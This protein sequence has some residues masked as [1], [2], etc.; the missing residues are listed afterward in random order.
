MEMKKRLER[1]VRFGIVLLSSFLLIGLV[2]AESS[3]SESQFNIIGCSLTIDDVLHPEMSTTGLPIGV[4]IGDCSRGIQK[5]WFYCNGDQDGLLTTDEG[6]GCSRGTDTYDGFLGTPKGNCCPLEYPIC[7]EAAPDAGVFQ[8]ERSLF[9]CN[10][11]L[12]KSVC[13]DEDHQ[14][15]YF[16]GYGCVCPPYQ[17]ACSLYKTQSG[18]NGDADG[19]NLGE[20]GYGVPEV[21]GRS[22]ECG[23]EWY[24]ITSCTCAWDSDDGIC[25]NKILGTETFKDDTPVDFECTRDSKMGACIDGEREVNWTADVEGDLPEECKSIL[26]CKDGSEMLACGENSVKLPGFSL[27]SLFMSLFIIGMYY[28]MSGIFREKEVI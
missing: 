26:G 12:I 18:C 4:K 6:I 28:F 15:Y 2:G 19:M 13:E 1:F 27:F 23:G 25:K 7:V 20:E 17:E 21:C 22:L 5:G 11:S 9:N 3:S 24:T 16:D 8:C 14:G 10:S